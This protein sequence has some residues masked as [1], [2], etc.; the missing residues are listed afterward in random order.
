MA[1]WQDW[2]KDAFGSV[3]KHFAGHPS[4]QARARRML[5][6]AMD[7]GAKWDDIESEARKYLADKGCLQ[8]HVEEQIAKMRDVASYLSAD[9]PD[10]DDLLG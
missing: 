7:A 5:K 8:T 4:D 2:L 6:K 9:S 1:T 3:D 10:D